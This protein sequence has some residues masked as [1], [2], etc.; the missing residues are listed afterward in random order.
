MTDDE[1]LIFDLQAEML[2]YITN[3]DIYYIADLWD[4]AENERYDD[5][6][7]ILRKRKVYRFFKVYFYEL[8]GA[9]RRT[10][11]TVPPPKNSW[12]RD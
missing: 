4:Y 10:K 3:N 7:P 6:L 12:H 8:R 11:K 5:W 1:K 9:M 2:D